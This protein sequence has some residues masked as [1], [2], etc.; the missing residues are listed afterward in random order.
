MEERKAG[1]ECKNRKF[2][3]IFNQVMKKGNNKEKVEMDEVE[4]KCV[5]EKRRKS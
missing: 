3:A 1:K 2:R 4:N 5:A